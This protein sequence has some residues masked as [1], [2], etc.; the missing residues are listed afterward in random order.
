MKITVKGNS[1]EKLEIRADEGL[2][3]AEP[4]LQVIRKMSRKLR[5]LLKN[6]YEIDLTISNENS[7]LE[8]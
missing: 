1:N 3:K 4:I 8:E 6:G 5:H 7:P 2:D